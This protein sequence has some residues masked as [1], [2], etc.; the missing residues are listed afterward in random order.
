MIIVDAAL[1]RREREGRPVQV[2]LVGAGY[3]G[4]GIA[5]E[6]LTPVRG[7]RLA[8]VANRTLNEARRAYV[9][10]GGGKAGTVHSGGRP[11]PADPTP[12]Y[13]GWEG[14]PLLWRAGNI[15]VN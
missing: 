4:R 1:E 3:M 14:A 6:I 5:L 15:D 8:A 12:P 9:E 7:M 13:P 2:G 10:A 11:A